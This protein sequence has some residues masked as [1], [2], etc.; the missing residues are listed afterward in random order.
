MRRQRRGSASTR[1][2][3]FSSTPGPSTTSSPGPFV[4]VFLSLPPGLGSHPRP[5]SVSFEMIR[6]EPP[7][8][9]EC[10]AVFSALPALPLLPPTCFLKG[11]SARRLKPV[12]FWLVAQGLLCGARRA[13]R[14]DRPILCSPRLGLATSPN[15]PPEPTGGWPQESRLWHWKPCWRHR[16]ILGTSSG[17]GRAFSTGLAR[18][19]GRDAGLLGSRRGGGSPG[20]CQARCRGAPRQHARQVHQGALRVPAANLESAGLRGEG[21]RLARPITTRTLEVIGAAFRAGAYRSAKEYFL[22]AFRYQEHDLRIEVDPLLRRFA[23]RVITRLS[24]GGCRAPASR[25]RSRS[26]HWHLWS[27]TRTGPPVVAVWFMLREI[28]VAAAR[29]GDMV[30]SPGLVVLDLPLHKT[31]TGGEKTLTRRSLRCACGA[32]RHPLCPVHAAMRHFTRLGAAGLLASLGPLFPGEGGGTL[33]K[34][35]SLRFLRGA[36]AAAGLE[37]VYRDSAGVERQTFGGHACRVAGATFLASSASRWPSYS[38]SADGRPGPLR[39]TPSRRHWLWPRR[40]PRPPWQVQPGWANRGAGRSWPPRSPLQ[41]LRLTR[42]SRARGTGHSWLPRTQHRHRSQT[43]REH[44][45]GP[46]FFGSGQSRNLTRAR[47]IISTSPGRGGFINRTP[48]GRHGAPGLW[49]ALWGTP[50]LSAV[51]PATRNGFLK[52]L[53]PGGP[54][55]LQRGSRE[56]LGLIVSGVGFF[57]V[58]SPSFVDL[59]VGGVDV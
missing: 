22:A 43:S 51:G 10:G 3:P 11:S 18:Q 2:G 8:K 30:V 44:R 13:G 21:A 42:V 52:T 49:L 38:C 39:D 17:R 48:T 15:S 27:T 31:A 5:Y 25:R 36:L 20:Q 55:G 40:R 24:S 29:V 1:T 16:G 41:T 57:T 59:R 9:S 4:Y 34:D 35:D 12:G 28:E 33:S 45:R 26:R 58:V 14:E 32:A 50:V 54:S 56:L 53:L 46:V 7:K 6:Q 23:N 47:S 19:K 37:T